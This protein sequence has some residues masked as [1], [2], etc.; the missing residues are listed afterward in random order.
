[1]TKLIYISPLRYPSEK[2]GSA[3]SMKSCEAFADLGYDV[4]LWAPRRKNHIKGDPFS[5]HNVKR[6]FRLVQLPAFDIS[7]LSSHFFLILSL[8]FAVS[9][10]FYATC[11]RLSLAIFYSHEEFG[12][13]LLTLR[14]SRTVY[15]IHDF[16]G[17][18]PLY[19]ML[20]SRVWKIVVTNN[21]KKN[22]LVRRFRISE[23]KTLAIPN[24][25]DVEQFTSAPERAEARAKLALP[26]NENSVV[27]TGHLYSWKG[28]D[29]LLEAVKKMLPEQ[30][31]LYM[32][33]GTEKDVR[34]Y[35][36]QYKALHNVVFTGM[37]PH[38]EIP[39][40]LRAADILV[41][42]NTAKE[43]ISK[44]YTSPMKLF[45]YMASGTPILASDLPSIREIVGDAEAVFF[46]PDNPASLAEKIGFM[47]L[48]ADEME[49]RRARTSESVLRYTWPK[50][51]KAIRE[52]LGD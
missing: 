50:R 42:P 11:R 32:V 41:L 34:E 37:R 45:E 10:F 12:L 35:R 13:F 4:E 14:F 31:R 24:A 38:E 43:N 33:G 39:L 17:K 25:V 29:T 15:E 23:Q 51:A 2:A 28:V 52:F 49:K 3:F 26:E 44:Y 22:E 36:E 40:W 27:Y 6:N 16:P 21:W 9:L 5:Y 1:M 20:L 46:E 7:G 18:N 30:V 19:R 48:H 47:L 8:T